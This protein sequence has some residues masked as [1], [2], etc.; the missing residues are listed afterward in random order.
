MGGLFVYL[1]L[2]V[3]DDIDR[4]LT[5]TTTSKAGGAWVPVLE[6]WVGWLLLL[7]YPA[8]LNCSLAFT[9]TAVIGG[10][11]TGEATDYRHH[12]SSPLGWSSSNQ[13]ERQ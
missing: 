8:P 7:A 4:F 12:H 3:G 5:S 6:P 1:W 11:T 10:F 2:L 13:R 9:E